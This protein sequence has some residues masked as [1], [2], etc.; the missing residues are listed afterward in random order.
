MGA[1][2]GRRAL[3]DYAAPVA[4]GPPPVP[5][6]APAYRLRAAKNRSL[7]VSTQYHFASSP[8]GLTCRGNPSPLRLQ[9]FKHRPAPALGRAGV[10][11]LACFVPYC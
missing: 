1:P 3:R 10:V 2:G 8:I 6:L 7:T 4:Y 11:D 5:P 9:A